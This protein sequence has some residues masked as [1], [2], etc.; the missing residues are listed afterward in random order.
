[1]ATLNCPR[2]E[3]IWHNP[4][5]EEHC[6]APTAEEME[7]AGCPY[8]DRLIVRPCPECGCLHEY[9]VR[10]WG[11][12]PI[13]WTVRKHGASGDTDGLSFHW[14]HGE[15]GKVDVPLVHLGFA[16]SEIECLRNQKEQLKDLIR[17][18]LPMAEDGLPLLPAGHTC[19]PEGNCDCECMAY[20]HGEQTLV[21][22]RK[23]TT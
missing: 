14:R 17:R 1:M 20:A 23:A 10:Q 6:G 18:L 4:K 3:C 19:G 9:A 13:K 15:L 12:G 2:T 11:S 5:S 7:T 21:E 22:A 8:M 16:F